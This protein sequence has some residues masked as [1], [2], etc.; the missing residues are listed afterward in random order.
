MKKYFYL[1]LAATT[2]A[3]C[4]NDVDYS[5]SDQGNPNNTIGF[6][7]LGRNS[8]TR[9]QSLQDAGHYNFGVFAYKSSDNVNNVMSNYLVG[10]MDDAKG[11]EKTGSTTGDKSGVADGQSYWMYEGLGKDEYFGTYAGGALTT[12]YT[13]N[14]EKQFLKY[15]D[16]SAG[17]TCFY[18]YAPYVGTTDAG[19]NLRVTYVDGQAQSATGGDTYVMNIPNGTIVAGYD[20]ASRYEFMYAS[21][22]VA[23][24]EYG[25][26]VSL[27]FNRLVAKVNIKFWEDIPGYKV[28]ILDL[29]EGTDGYHGVQAAASIK[30]NTSGKYGYKGGKYY[31]SNGV[32]IKFIDGKMTGIKQYKGETKDNNIP[33]V[34]DAPT[35]AKIGENRY[36]AS[37]SA[38]TYYAIPKGAK[39]NDNHDVKVLEVTTAEGIKT[40]PDFSDAGVDPEAELSQ[41][42]FTFHV[43][44]EL[45]AE[46]SGERII[47]KNATVHVPCN[48]CNWKENTHYTYIFKITTNSNGSSE[49]DPDIKPT[50]PEVPTVQSLYPIVFDNCTVQDWGEDESEWEI[51]EGT[52][53]SYH[54]ITLSV[55]D[56]ANE[57]PTYSVGSA[58]ATLKVTIADKDGHNNN[59]EIVYEKTHVKVSG[60]ATDAD[61]W[62]TAATDGTHG[63]ITVP[64]NAAAGVYTVT[65]TCPDAV[66]DPSV[67]G[68]HNSNHPRTW[69]V[70]FY[71]GES[72]TVSTHEE[73]I[74]T[75]YNVR[76]SASTD[77]DYARLNVT[78]TRNSSDL[79]ISYTDLSIDYPKNITDHS[80]VYI[81][82]AENT[83]Q[84]VVKNTAAP[85]TYKVILKQT[86]DGQT[87]KVAEKTFEVKDFNFD[88]D[89]KV[90]YNNGTTQT[91]T[92]SMPADDDHKYSTT[93]PGTV[94]ATD[95]NKIDV[96]GGTDNTSYTITYTVYADG[97]AAQTKYTNTFEVRNTHEVTLSK[98]SIDRNLGT[99]SAGATT[100]DAITVTTKI[101]GV[102]TTDDLTQISGKLTVVKSD[103]NDTPSGDFTITYDSATHTYTLKCKNTVAPGNYYV[104]FMNTV[105]GTDTPEFA[106]FVVVE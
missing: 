27:D 100:T 49:T 103:K 102:A 29:K 83:P 26:D 56:G 67:S 18:A 39:D 17:F 88:I 34:F 37:A 106:S 43:S 48:Y 93:T 94:N 53:L 78:A 42:G 63:T 55:I 28:R 82:T 86:V 23:N 99:G 38:T 22:K 75:N 5:S 45:T 57:V 65:Y 87:V 50:D 32:K 74:G 98:N 7:V 76:E 95:K 52:D 40:V 85:G 96:T 66:S 89:Q 80:N 11:Y 6:Q 15:W 31:V 3:A 16:K 73:V 14:N 21:A 25:H 69:T 33:L 1:A 58:G 10:Y 81:S 2:M 47:V 20:D 60:P 9:A 104:K 71:V 19:K 84:V 64:A 36:T 51:T 46:D 54:N 97:D 79:S 105:A 70:K 59:H 77:A 13:S 24:T 44:Y 92:C 61:N 90:I 91:I 72:Y 35:D 62:Y 68:D 101:N 12:F 4:T 41:T 30:D 8:I